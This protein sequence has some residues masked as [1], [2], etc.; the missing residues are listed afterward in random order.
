MSEFIKPLG[1]SIKETAAITSESEWQVKA[2]LSSGEYKAKKAGRRTIIDYQ[3]VEDVWKSLP[4]WKNA[5]RPV[6]EKTL[7]AAAAG[8]RRQAAA[9]RAAAALK[10][11]HTQHLESGSL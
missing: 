11:K 6:S 3:S 5:K 10:C 4:D 1:L 8:R 2:R 7:K 9:K